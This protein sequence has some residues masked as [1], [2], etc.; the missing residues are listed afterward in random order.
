MFFC[1][2]LFPASLIILFISGYA[3][4]QIN[5]LHISNGEL[6]TFLFDSTSFIPN[7]ISELFGT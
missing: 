1:F 3:L 7:E 5:T 4:K 2:V 6:C